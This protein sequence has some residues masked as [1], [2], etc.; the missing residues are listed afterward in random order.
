MLYRRP[1]SQHWWCRFTS[2]NGKEIRRTTKTS[3]RKAAQEY[4][5]KLKASIWRNQHLQEKPQ[6]SWQEAAVKWLEE[7]TYKNTVAGDR[8]S[9]RYADAFLG[10]KMLHEI[11]RELLLELRQAKLA[12]GVSHATVNRMLEVIRAILNKAVRE[13]EW[14][15][16]APVVK[17]LPEPKRRVRW[18]TQQEITNLMK[19]LP[20]HLQAMAMFSLAT[21]LRESNV[22]QLEWSQIDLTRKVAWIH[23]D[24]AKAK[25]AIGVALNE[26]AIGVLRK[27]LGKH[28]TKVFTYKGK[29]VLKANTKAWR[30][31][32]HRAGIENFRWHD[33]RHTWASMHVQAGTS[34][35]VLQELGSWSDIRMV[36]RYAHLAPE[37]LAKFANNIAL[38]KQEDKGI[39]TLSGTPDC[40]NKKAANDE[41]LTA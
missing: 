7:A 13:W 10:Q 25:K 26:D 6:H 8:S 33:L 39:R 17:M 1:N 37:H 3:N 32:L 4:E 27:Q 22:T 18:L 38:P 19:E 24:Q 29:P 36:Q 5:V 9:L 35:H 14:L 21:G 30:Q 28:N 16:K 31:A 20:E 40:R 11:D 15:D 34:I 23:A 2:P 12:T 41:S